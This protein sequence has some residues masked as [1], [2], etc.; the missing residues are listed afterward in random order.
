MY[1]WPPFPWQR[2]SASSSSLQELFLLYLF[3]YRRH[4]GHCCTCGGQKATLAF[5][6]LFPPCGSR[7]LNS[8]QQAWPQAPSP[9]EPS[10]W[11]SSNIFKAEPVI[12][13]QTMRYSNCLHSCHVVAGVKG[14]VGMIDM[15]S[16]VLTD[17]QQMLQQSTVC[18]GWTSQIPVPGEVWG[19]ALWLLR[20]DWI[21]HTIDHITHIA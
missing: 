11:P 17:P 16:S 2:A 7:E 18:K 5:D 20:R 8:G 4:T 9:P 10:H 13:P 3:I 1:N 15:C 12:V 21:C 19:Q 14:H 6:Y